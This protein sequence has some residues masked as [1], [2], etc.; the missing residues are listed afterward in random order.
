LDGEVVILNKEGKPEF[1]LLQNFQRTRKGE[2][3]YYV[4]DLLY[5]NGYELFDLPLLK[6]KKFLKEILNELDDPSVLYSDHVLAKGISLFKQAQ[7]DQLE[8]IIAKKADSSYYPNNRS[9]N[10]LKIKTSMR[11]EAVIA[12]F[13]EPRGSRKTFGALVLGLY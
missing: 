2:L 6:R 10:W 5:L 7:G 1:Q 9:S 4:F 13:T 11:Q 12:G 8:G 3:F